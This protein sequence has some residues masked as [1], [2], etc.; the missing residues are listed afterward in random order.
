MLQVV[1]LGRAGLE[2]ISDLGPIKQ[3]DPQRG[4]GLSREDLTQVA[5]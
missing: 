3:I 5:N 2:S 1:V 4:F